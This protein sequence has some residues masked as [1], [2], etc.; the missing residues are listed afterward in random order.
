MEGGAE[1]SLPEQ[2]Q[3]SFFD[4]ISDQ[5]ITIAG[6][7]GIVKDLVK[8]CPV[9]DDKNIMTSEAMDEFAA[10]AWV[11]SGNELPEGYTHLL[12]TNKS[13]GSKEAAAEEDTAKPEVK[14][15]SQEPT[16]SV[17][18]EPELGAAPAT[19][20]DVRPLDTDKEAQDYLEP[21]TDVSP[22]PQQPNEEIEIR[23]AT[24][25]DEI[26][27][28]KE[29]HAAEVDIL[30]RIPEVASNDPL[31][32]EAVVPMVE[33][34]SSNTIEGPVQLEPMEMEI[35]E[36][37]EAALSV[38]QTR[39]ELVVA[40][41]K[42][43]GAESTSEDNLFIFAESLDESDRSD[44]HYLDFEDEIK[45]FWDRYETE[46]A[47]KETTS[48]ELMESDLPVSPDSLEELFAAE[49]I[50]QDETGSNNE[51]PSL[52]DL[53]DKK[54]DL[55]E[56]VAERQK[57]SDLTVDIQQEISEIADLVTESFEPAT[58][59]QIADVDLEDIDNINEVRQNVVALLEIL[60]QKP[61]KKTVDYFIKALI[62]ETV[63]SNLSSKKHSFIEEGTHEI[64]K[65][66][67]ELLNTAMFSISGDRS[68]L[69]SLIGRYALVTT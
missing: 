52:K 8:L 15:N 55:V 28:I 43:M 36:D 9:R 37:K 33:L 30:E 13:D 22:E 58:D 10:K 4:R 11:A 47:L 40:I 46:H 54:I 53:I 65:D 29:S 49:D 32:P 44:D 5:E 21:R 23:T 34:K 64:K 26:I 27:R 18:I 57:A 69:M 19:E 2:D 17:K 31:L 1:Q 63:N 61:N 51:Q 20:E 68:V 66:I 25:I 42:V 60:N 41:D 12:D 39:S 3:Q 48:D 56:D 45:E 14:P 6:Y 67:S 35:I 24:E 59:I 7:T 62:V 16:L 38:D 50:E